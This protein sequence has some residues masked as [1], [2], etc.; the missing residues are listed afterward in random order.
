MTE[1]KDWIFPKKSKHLQRAEGNER[2]KTKRWHDEKEERWKDAKNGL[3]QRM[4]TRVFSE[5]GIR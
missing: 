5:R 1:R 3:R 4:T 2:E